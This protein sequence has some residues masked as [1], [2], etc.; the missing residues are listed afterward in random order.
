MY[1]TIQTGGFSNSRP[2]SAYNLPNSHQ[3]PNHSSPYAPGPSTSGS[4]GQGSSPSNAFPLLRVHIAEPYRTHP[5]VMVGPGLDDIER[6]QF[7]FDFDLE[8]QLL[9]DGERRDASLSRQS[10]T[11]A[12]VADPFSTLVKHWV[13]K[14]FGSEE[15]AL[16]LAAQ[17]GRLEGNDAQVAEFC[18]GFKA[19]KQMGF[20][21]D[22]IAGALME[23]KNDLQV[24]T[25]MCLNAQR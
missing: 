11:S 14:G 3:Q 6:T 9:A 18:K 8:R 17:K 19:L 12:Q 15:V 24:A 1:P 25:D 21:S 20:R 4:D 7:S 13:D 22:L 5:P 10:S 23:S 2:S 16:A